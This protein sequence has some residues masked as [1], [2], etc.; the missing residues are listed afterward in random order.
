MSGAMPFEICHGPGLS[1]SSQTKQFVTRMTSDKRV[2]RATWPVIPASL[3]VHED[4][5][6][7][8]TLEMQFEAFA[9]NGSAETVRF[10]GEPGMGEKVDRLADSRGGCPQVDS[11]GQGARAHV[12]L[13]GRQARVAPDSK[14]AVRLVRA[15]HAYWE[16]LSAPLS[17]PAQLSFSQV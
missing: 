8:G 6:N 11:A 5:K 1:A 13:I 4:A 14:I 3:Q 17:Q 10:G 7:H 16:P 9:C 2:P 12:W 15:T